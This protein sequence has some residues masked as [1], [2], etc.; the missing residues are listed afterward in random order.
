MKIKNLIFNGVMVLAIISIAIGGVLLT[1][2]IKDS[3][4]N[5]SVFTKEETTES[6]ADSNPSSAESI[7]N[8]PGDVQSA[9]P[10]QNETDRQEVSSSEPEM[11]VTVKIECEALLQNMDK[12]KQGKGEFVPPDGIILPET[13]VQ[14]SDGDTVYDV[15]S[16]ICREKGIQLECAF[17]PLY[18]SYYIE[19]INQLYEF[20]C[21]S[22]SGWIYR[23]NGWKPDYGVS[24]YSLNAGDVIYLHYTCN[25][26]ED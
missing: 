15:V 24:A 20:D 14:I 1:R 26:G 4:Q 17:T 3:G 10:Q 6:A 8:V 18:N 7:P 13:K 12:L 2:Q 16:G 11:Y 5:A 21:G 23:V 22:G 19:G 25:Y 9:A